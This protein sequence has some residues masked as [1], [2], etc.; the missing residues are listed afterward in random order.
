VIVG[1]MRISVERVSHEPEHRI[2]ERGSR[3]ADDR[4]LDLG[5]EVERPFGG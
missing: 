2:D 5:P 3:I 4:I 1:G